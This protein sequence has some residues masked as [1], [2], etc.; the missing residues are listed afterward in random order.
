[1]FK[2][3]ERFLDRISYLEKEWEHESAE[4]VSEDNPDGWGEFPFKGMN[5]KQMIAFAKLNKFRSGFI[6]VDV[7]ILSNAQYDANLKYPTSEV[8]KHMNHIAEQMVGRLE[9][10]APLNR[11]KSSNPN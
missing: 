11:P 10:E 8:T 9:L 5:S 3:S 6:G 1:L 4:H 2:D 7:P